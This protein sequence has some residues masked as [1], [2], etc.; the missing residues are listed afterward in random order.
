MNTKHAAEIKIG[1]TVV[2]SDG[3]YF[4]VF[5]IEDLGSRLLFG[6]RNVNG[7]MFSAR[8]ARVSKRAFVRVFG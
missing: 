5:S 8:E 7:Y 4:E 6:L 3:S 2:E 1:D